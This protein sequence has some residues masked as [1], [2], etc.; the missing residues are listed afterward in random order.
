LLFVPRYRAAFFVL[1]APA[2]A[3]LFPEIA[4]TPDLNP[5]LERDTQMS[6][7]SST[8]AQSIPS[9]GP[10]PAVMGTYGRFDIV[11]DHG[12]GSWL[13]DT[14]GERYL[15]FGSGIA[16]NALGHAHPKLIAALTE[17]A[18]KL[19]HTSNLYR[20]AGQ[21]K[22]AERLVASTF[23]DKV[24][25]CNSGAEACE[26]IIKLARRYQ[27]ASGHPEKWRIITFKGSFHGRT[28]GTIAAAGNEKYL[29]GFGEPAPGFDVLETV[30][31]LALVEKAIGPATA[32]IMVEPIQGEGGIR[33]CTREFLQGLRAL[34]DKNG[35]LL[36]LDEVQT[37]VGRTGK[38]FA[39]E[40]AGIK[41]DAMAI[42]KGIGGGFPVG[43]FLATAE[44]AKGMVPGTHGSTFGGNPLAMAVGDAVLE[45][46]LEPGF[47][48][49]VQRKT[50]RF[51]QLLARLKDEHADIVDEIRGEGLLIGVKIN[52]KFLAG[53]VVKAALGE[54]LLTVGAGDNVVR[55]IPPL[56]TPDDELAEG[57]SRLSRA[58][59][60]VKS[61][62]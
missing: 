21:E 53:D 36:I 22:L 47:L 33:A 38:L 48:E 49:E 10:S 62:K 6:A 51:K 45:T 57:V 31:D 3:P 20:V 1:D 27:F 11:F 41:P 17:Q 26:G 59:A 4:A 54:H 46:V 7:A 30:N 35:L 61:A 15:D 39:Y 12:E 56:T 44:A 42:A 50:L 8:A 23:A 19:W 5:A 40:A 24:F 60:R 43:A 28:L 58:L 2:K 32:A 14:K 16:V 18:G 13:I 25:F 9:S 55:M 52:A 34:A 29:E 37:G